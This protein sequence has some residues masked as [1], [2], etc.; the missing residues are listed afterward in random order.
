MIFFYGSLSSEQSRDQPCRA[1]ADPMIPMPAATLRHTHTQS[2][3]TAP[4]I[5]D[6][7]PEKALAASMSSN[8]RTS[9]RKP[10]THA[11]TRRRVACFDPRREEATAATTA[12]R[13]NN[14]FAQK[15]KTA[16]SGAAPGNVSPRTSGITP[17]ATMAAETSM[18]AAPNMSIRCRHECIIVPPRIDCDNRRLM[19]SS[20]AAAPHVSARRVPYRWRD[21][22]GHQLHGIEQRDGAAPGSSHSRLGRTKQELKLQCYSAFRRAIKDATTE[23]AYV[24]PKLESR[25]PSPWDKNIS[26]FST[27]VIIVT[28]TRA[29]A[30]SANMTGQSLRYA[31][32]LPR[33]SRN[34]QIRK[35]AVIT[36]SAANRGTDSPTK[37][38]KNNERI[39]RQRAINNLRIFVSL[40]NSTSY[41]Y[42]MY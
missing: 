14:T 33:E 17:N 40:S 27:R 23:P 13:T 29:V 7:C 26:R 4:R 41:G 8:P 35:Y 21:G 19:P 11:S 9:A 1:N 2:A 6:P 37:K 32:A 20:A 25:S 15:A 10:E 39:P 42:L 31:C 18:S 5:P 24:P 34:W 36:M 3:M 12:R 38:Y 28:I 16:W 30:T 22:S